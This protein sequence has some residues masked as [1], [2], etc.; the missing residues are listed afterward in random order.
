LSRL[1][2][3]IADNGCGL[4]S[5]ARR[6]D[7]RITTDEQAIVWALEQGTTSAVPADPMAQRSPEEWDLRADD[8]CHQGLGLWLLKRLVERTSGRL[9]M[10]TGSAEYLLDGGV[11][12]TQSHV[13][14]WSGVV[15][16]LEIP[17][18]SK[19][20]VSDND[21]EDLGLLAEELAI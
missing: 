1:E 8:D 4:L 15:I 10:L 6:T 9:W 11:V 5:N 12:T 19:E 13:P 17:V 14:H 18:N 3:A 20:P 7:R 21:T 16:E 2:F